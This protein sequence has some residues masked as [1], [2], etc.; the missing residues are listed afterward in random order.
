MFDVLIIVELVCALEAEVV[1]A[2]GALLRANSKFHI[3]KNDGKRPDEP[4]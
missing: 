1:L 2:F 3:L 4:A